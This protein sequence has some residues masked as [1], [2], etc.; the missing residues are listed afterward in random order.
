MG[1]L[2]DR[3]NNELEKSNSINEQALSR[4]PVPWTWC[5][6]GYGGS[7]PVMRRWEME[8]IVTSGARFPKVSVT[9]RARNQSF[10]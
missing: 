3:I 8:T 6:G 2:T 1:S 9:F 5:K 7:V 10:N 4:E